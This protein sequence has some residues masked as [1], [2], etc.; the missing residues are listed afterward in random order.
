MSLGLQYRKPS[1]R[2]N[3]WRRLIAA[4]RVYTRAS[5]TATSVG[6]WRRRRVRK[7]GPRLR[8]LAIVELEHTAEPLTALEGASSDHLCLRRDELVAE[9]LV[10]A[11][12]M[13]MVHELS[14][15]SPE[16]L[17]AERDDSFQV[18][19]LGGQDEP[20]R[21]GVEVGTPGWQKHW[22]HAAILEH[23]PEGGGVEG[24]PVENE[25]AHTAKESV[26]RVGQ[27]SCDLRHPGFVRLAGDS[28]D[29]HGARLEAHH[30]EDEVPDQS[31]AWSAPRR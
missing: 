10:R 9:A 3:G 16:V 11:F 28:R 30:E 2:R 12:F 14:N 31:A 19:G 8:G 26:L 25:I 1:R 7:L 13:V 18:L 29:L 5:V 21:I 24:I 17:L 4:A 23:A 27:V 22:S 15:G 6:R 20:F